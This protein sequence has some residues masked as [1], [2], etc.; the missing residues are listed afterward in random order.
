MLYVYIRSG[1]SMSE[2]AAERVAAKPNEGDREH[3]ARDNMLARYA[4]ETG[5]FSQIDFLDSH[6]PIQFIRG[7]RAA[8]QKDYEEAQRA[9]G[10]LAASNRDL[11]YGGRRTAEV[12]RNEVLASMFAARGDMKEAV[13]IAQIAVEAEAAR[14][15]PFRPYSSRLTAPLKLLESGESAPFSGSIRASLLRTRSH[16]IRGGFCEIE[17]R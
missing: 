17:G 13:R 3:H 1:V 16:Y 6:A 2:A 9:V 8:G 14:V 7:L 10:T 11:H 12:L 15:R 5:D 4:L